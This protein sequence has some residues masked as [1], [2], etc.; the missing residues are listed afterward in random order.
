MITI[1]TTSFNTITMSDKGNSLR[2]RTVHRCGHQHERGSGAGRRPLCEREARP[3]ALQ[4]VPRP[5]GVSRSP[6]PTSSSTTTPF[7]GWLPDALHAVRGAMFQA[8][9]NG[10][11]PFRSV[12]NQG[13]MWTRCRP[14]CKR[15]PQLQ[16]G[17]KLVTR[18]ISIPLRACTEVNPF[19]AFD[20]SENFSVGLQE[21]VEAFRRSPA[22]TGIS[23]DQHL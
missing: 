18:Q 4:Y 21:R 23:L 22:F 19:S 11:T 16:I 5:P 12:A 20:G 9:S 13:V 10:L 17:Y 8:V 15:A 2:R 14:A 3:G 7:P 1:A 6:Y